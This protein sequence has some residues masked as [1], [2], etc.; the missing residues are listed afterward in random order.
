MNTKS[1][2]AVAF[3]T[4]VAAALF[5]IAPAFAADAVQAAPAS[6]A[7]TTVAASAATVAAAQSINSVTIPTMPTSRS[8]AEV[9]AEAVDFVAHYKTALEMQLELS[10]N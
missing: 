1:R 6:A 9:H 8:R 5:A 10:K 7:A 2:F 3:T 4:T